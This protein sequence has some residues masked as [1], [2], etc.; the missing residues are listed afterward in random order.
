MF[1]I[2]RQIFKC[3]PLKARFLRFLC[4]AVAC[5]VANCFVVSGSPLPASRTNPVSTGLLELLDLSRPELA[6]VRARAEADD[7]PGALR[8]YRSLLARRMAKLPAQKSH[9]FWLHSPAEADRLL[10][11]ELITARYG[12]TKVLYTVPIGKPGRID[13]FKELPQYREIARDIS[14]MQWVN[15]YCEAYG[16][17]KDLK[18]LQAW[19]ETW[20][21]YLAHWDAQWAGVKANPAVWGRGASR[22]G[23]IGGIEWAGGQTLY[24]AWRMSAMRSGVTAMLQLASANGQLEQLDSEVLSGLL[25]RLSTVEMA[26]ARNSLRGAERAVPNQV[27]G[28]AEE[29]LSCGLTFTEF[30]D[31]KAWR[32]ESIPVCYLTSQPDGTSREQSLG[33]FI[34]Y[35]PGLIKKL[36]SGLPRNELDE[37]LIGKIERLNQY[38][39]RVLPSLSRP[40]GVTPATGSGNIWAEYGKTKPLKPPSAA[41][42]SILFPFGGYAIQRDGWKPESLYLFMKAARPNQGHWR[43]MEAGLQLSAYGRNLL[44][45]PV[46]NLYDTHDVEGGWRLYWESA[47]GQNTIVVDG[48]S[49]AER[50]GGFNKLDSMRWHT[51]QRFD[52]METEVAGPY[53]GA[54]PRTAGCAYAERKKRGEV[55]DKP[56]ITDVVHRRQVHFLREAGL[57]VV[58]DR[59]R[60]ATPHD[61]TQTWCYGPEYAEG[62]VVPD[63]AGK[64]IRTRQ[65]NAPN[66]SLYQF[67]IPALEYRKYFGVYSDESILGWV[68]IMK[69]P[70]KWTYTP[71]V[72]VHVNW[73]GEG[74]QI[75][76]TLLCPRR[77]MEEVVTAVVDRAANGVKGF[78]A[79]LAGN[80]RI[81]YRCSVDAAPLKA[82]GME[83]D[84]ASLLVLAEATGRKSGVVLNARS[85]AGKQPPVAD[86]EFDIAGSASSSPAVTPIHVPSGF[87]WAGTAEQP[88]PEY[89]AGP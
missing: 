28:L 84:A 23:R 47:I 35:F 59:I 80:R 11:G 8:E 69:D 50:K 51:S 12:D 41:F 78:D 75:L 74:D 56:A 71:A 37:T 13:F 89:T 70:V 9:S 4:A 79:T 30:K 19:C 18:W 20:R 76:V 58:T 36:R 88:A 57:W 38:Q 62:E 15:K 29:V 1:S 83:T 40:D 22:E 5:I 42:T 43:P 45:S 67:G 87:R 14:T 77:N 68:G 86:F 46:G 10:E 32:E 16:K 39:Q 64:I 33:Y 31:S 72:N 52:F 60:G 24:T 85:F 61:F 2:L 55:T 21:D 44:A 26:N 25:V 7:L 34:N 81:F 27:R 73:R 3:N 54:D 53:T 63:A 66:L 6:E 17:S 82:E 65:S 49:A 48:M